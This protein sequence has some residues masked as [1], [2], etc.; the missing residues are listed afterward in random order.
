MSI[1]GQPGPIPEPE[2]ADPVTQ[3][4]FTLRCDSCQA[5]VWS[6]D[7]APPADR[8]ATLTAFADGQCPRGGTAGGCPH[9]T[10]ARVAALTNRGR[11]VLATV[12]ALGPTA[13]V[14]VTD[15]GLPIAAATADTL[16]PGD[17]VVIQPAADRW[18]VTSRTV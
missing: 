14:V 11:A 2:P 7:E 4:R 6:S 5:T 12:T 17:R 18:A 1:P 15:T 8:Q 10:Q 3:G 16:T 9:T 13:A